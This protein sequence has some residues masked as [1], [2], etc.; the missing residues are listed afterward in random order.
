M[1]HVILVG[2]I[3]RGGV[4]ASIVGTLNVLASADAALIKGFLVNK[5]RG[6]PELF[7][8]GIEDH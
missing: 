7:T 1:Y 2:D 3:D 5:F 4:I 8:D 6:D